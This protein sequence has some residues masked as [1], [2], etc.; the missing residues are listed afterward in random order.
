MSGTHTIIGWVQRIQTFKR[1][2]FCWIR[3]VE[4]K[5]IWQVVYT[6]KIDFFEESFVR[7]VGT[8]VPVKQG[9]T[10][11]GGV[12]ITDAVITVISPAKEG[13]PS[14]VP[15]EAANEIKLDL[16]HH[17]LRDPEFIEVT[18][19]RD[20]V[21]RAIR[22]AFHG[23]SEI[24][25]PSFVG[26]QCEGGATLFELEHP[27]SSGMVQAY[28]TQS[29]Q[30]YLEYALPGVGDCFCI[31][32]SFRKENSHTRRHLTEF[33]HAESEWHAIFS[34]EQ[35]EEKLEKLLQDILDYLVAQYDENKF[36]HLKIRD[37]LVTLRKMCG[38]ILRLDHAEAIVK[39]NEMGGHLDGSGPFQPDEDIPEAEE[40]R[41]I[42][43]IGKIVFLRKFPRVFKSF[44]MKPDPDHPDLVWGVDVEVPGVG[45]IIGSGVRESDPDKLSDAILKQGLKLEDY[46]EYI[47]LRRYG[48][49]QTSGMGLGVDR[50]ITWL[51]D[52]FS[53]REVVTYPRY[54]GRLAP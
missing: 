42:D 52:K 41:L 8:I 20:L 40:R 1:H 48:A 37:R 4:R 38:E 46:K 31:A 44:Y 3:D 53:I 16:R 21:V 5:Q 33:L 47:D 6:G 7:V 54:P 12:E 19:F 17:Y 30:F 2:S 22:H 28:L 50:L 14:L 43:H 27:G 35:H 15:R 13:F 51:L 24:F 11:P 36:V 34:L 26:N 18:R 29:S 39:C 45:E 23:M 32:P 10:A 9:Q 25:P 49:G